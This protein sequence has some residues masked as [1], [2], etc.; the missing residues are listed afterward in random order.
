M[1]NLRHSRSF[2]YVLFTAFIVLFDPYATAQQSDKRTA[3]FHS[4]SA[5]RALPFEQL[6]RGYPALIRG[7][8]TASDGGL[9]V[10]DATEGIWVYWNRAQDYAPGDEIEVQ[11][12]IGPGKFAPVVNATSVRKLGT[13][14]LPKPIPVTFDQLSS[15]TFDVQYVTFTGSIRSVGKFEDNW[16]SKHLVM[17]VE[18]GNGTLMVTLPGGHDEAAALL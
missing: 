18:S 9:V 15:G 4:V 17:R 6:N 3:V 8:V 2:T 5:I 13:A 16:H 1:K 10:H 14:P 12:S 7:V 11:G